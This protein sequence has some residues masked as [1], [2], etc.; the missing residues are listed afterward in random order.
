MKAI[1]RAAQW[2]ECLEQVGFDIEC[3]TEDRF[4]S[5]YLWV[6]AKKNKVFI[7]FAVHM[8]TKYTRFAIGS[9]TSYG[10]YRCTRQPSKMASAIFSE[11]EMERY[12][13]RQVVT[14]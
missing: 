11:I 13:M 12:R 3:E 7:R 8:D 9:V 1:D 2:S 5:E 10:W 6:S 4:G 14:A